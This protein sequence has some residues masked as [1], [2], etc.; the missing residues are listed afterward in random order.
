[1][2]ALKT[3]DVEDRKKKVLQS[4]IHRYIKSARPVGSKMLSELGVLGLS[5]ATIR[6]TLADL[7]EEGYITHPHT[8]AGRIPTD[9]GYRYYVETLVEIQ[10]LAVEEQNRIQREYEARVRELHDLMEKTSHILS[11][12]SH[13]TGFVLSPKLSYNRLMHLEL[14]KLR[15]K[16]ILMVMVTD[17]GLIKHQVVAVDWEVSPAKLQR[18]KNMLNEKLSGL[19]LQEVQA[20][21]IDKLREE[22]ESFHELF[23]LGASL[24]KQ[25][26]EEV[27]DDLIVDGASNLLAQG[28]FEDVSQAQ[29][30]FKLI[31]EKKMLSKILRKQISLRTKD[32]LKVTIGGEGMYPELNRVS[33]ISSVYNMQGHHVG[34]LG[35]IGP[36]R[37]E[38]AHMIS[39]VRYVTEILNNIFKDFEKDM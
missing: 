15:D 18:L 21:F 24:G 29:L 1:M 13:Y 6:N 19:T 30:V 7:E 38:Y 16:K 37:M 26:F 11:T 20:Q 27:E 25:L 10:R 32:D 22:E 3:E 39:L 12:V 23:S 35:I 31:D 5:P 14:A 33:M 17:S 28:D 2:R 36:K 34:V 8:S 4:V 9:K